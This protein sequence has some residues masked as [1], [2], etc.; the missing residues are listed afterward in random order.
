MHCFAGS[1]VP[2]GD[3]HSVG[4]ELRWTSPLAV[5]RKSGSQSQKRKPE[6]FAF[7]RL[8]KPAELGE[9]PNAPKPAGS[10]RSV[11]SGVPAAQH[12]WRRQRNPPTPQ[13]TESAV[14]TGELLVA[15]DVVP[16]RVVRIVPHVFAVVDFHNV[17][18]WVTP[19]FDFPHS[20]RTG[21]GWP[22]ADLVGLITSAR[23]IIIPNDLRHVLPLP[24][25]M[26]GIPRCNSP[27]SARPQKYC[28]AR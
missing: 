21:Y 7:R 14:T 19:V 17:C 15:V 8:P 16:L 10:A 12:N 2:I 11:T 1:F 26:T 27:T 6:G 18:T 23:A 4:A 20:L 22:R 13:N 24:A 5:Q 25:L 3:T 9:S 28:R